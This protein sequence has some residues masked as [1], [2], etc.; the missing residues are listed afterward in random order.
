M[1]FK[2]QRV[3]RGLGQ[4]LNLFGGTIDLLQFYGQT[5]LSYGQANN[6]ALAEGGAIALNLAAPNTV[7]VL[8]NV[9]CAIVKTATMTA[10]AA[11]VELNRGAGAAASI[12]AE[13]DLGP[14]GATATGLVIVGGMLPYPV[15][16]SQTAAVNA[17]L[18][19][20]GTDANANVTIYAEYGI[21]G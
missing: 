2:I 20:L 13:N 11:S 18:N 8:F 19:I 12:F 6:A 21:L 15:L 5:Q 17:R 9:W 4:L 10:L 16:C 14:F 1:P 3:P 7:C